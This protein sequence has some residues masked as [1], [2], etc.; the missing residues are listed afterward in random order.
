M[1]AKIKNKTK[2]H[3]KAIVQVTFF[4]MIILLRGGRFEIYNWESFNK[5]Y[6]NLILMLET[7]CLQMS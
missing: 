4:T 5:R 3:N 1:W 6:V 7:V 2:A